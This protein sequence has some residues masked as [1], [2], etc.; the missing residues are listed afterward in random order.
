MDFMNFL[1]GLI[2]TVCSCG[3]TIAVLGGVGFFLYRMF[4]GNQKNKAILETG[5]SAPATIISAQEGSVAVSSG[6]SRSIQVHLT[7]QVMPTNRPPF[8][9]VATTMVGQLQLGLISPGAQVQVKYDPN[10]ITK[11][12]IE[13]L[14]S[15]MPAAN[16]QALQNAVLSQDQYYEKLRQT[17]EEALATIVL[18]EETNIR[19]G[20]EGSLFRFTMDVTPNVGTPF[21]AETQAAIADRSRYKYAVGKK[22]YV[23]FDPYGDKKQ[24]AID[25][26]VEQ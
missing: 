12:A 5:V 24:V 15:A 3:I 13:S 1:P 7:L 22:V 19:A 8:Q 4:Q 14:G 6:I 17:G 16:V 9:A 20:N 10:D 25:R 26:A 11:V 2:G 23:R 18:A 21:R